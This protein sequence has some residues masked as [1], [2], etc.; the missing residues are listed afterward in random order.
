VHDRQVATWPQFLLAMEERLR[1]FDASKGEG[2]FVL[3]GTVSSPTLQAQLED[4]RTRYPRMQWHQY[5]P[6]HRDNE[7]RGSE[8]AFGRILD[9]RYRLDRARVLLTL[10]ADVICGGPHSTR[11]ARDL[12]ALRDPE[13]GP[14]SRI[15][16]L[17]SFPGLIGA[18]ADHRV[19]LRPA[20]IADLALRF[21]RSIL[22]GAALPGDAESLRLERPLLRDLMAA[23]REALVIPGSS[24]PAEVHAAAHALNHRFGGLG[25][26]FEHTLPVAFEPVAHIESIRQ[27]SAAMTEGRVK[28]LLIVGGNPVYDAPADLDFAAQL[29][30]VPE[31]IH[32][33]GY[34]D[35]TSLQCRW[36]VPLAHELEQ[37]SDV[38]AFDGTASIVQPTIA[39][40]YGGR[41]AH[42]ILNVLLR[43]GGTAYDAVRA[44]WRARFGSAADDERWRTSLRDGLV[45]GSQ[46]PAVSISPRPFDS[47]PT[48]PIPAALTVGFVPDQSARDGEFANNAWLQEL[49]RSMSKIVWDN[50]AYLSPR[51]AARLQLSTGDEIELRRA[52]RRVHAGV[53][54]LPAHADD[55]VTLPLG[56]GRTHAGDVGNGVGFDA[57]QLRTM[58][59]PWDGPVQIARTG[60]HRV[61]VSTQHHSRMEGRD[62]I[63]TA[64]ASEFART[65]AFATSHAQERVPQTTLYPDFPYE[66]YKW[67]MV[68]DLN[69]CIG[70]N[71]C[72]IACQAEN[73]IPVVGKE[74]VMRGREM[75]WLRI[76]RYERD[77]GSGVDFQPVACMH[78]ERAPCEEVCPVGATLHDSEGLNV[79]VYNRC[80]GTRF[81]SNNCPYKVR[82]FNFLQYSNQ[83]VEPLKALQNPEVTVRER[84]VMEKCSYCIQRITRGHIAAEKLGRRIQDG[85]VVTAC[86]AACPT[87]A[88]SFGDLN[89]PSSQVG[90]L[91][92]SPRNYSLL[93]QLN[94][95]PRTT[96]LAQVVNPDADSNES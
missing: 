68:I 85:E 52:G 83:S 9:T 47:L 49:P 42:E 76:D 10:D 54:I 44:Y 69:A 30:R 41:S 27:L 46:A 84:G 50:A 19:A 92:A 45:A 48:P 77:D 73:N 88:I 86:Q 36:H 70:C 6:L 89:D 24:M 26:T 60:R 79:Q 53:W 62:L 25:H 96:Y 82:R 63:R 12:A 20:A 37:W 17:E 67:G 22:Q 29:R 64:T 51:T 39:P 32:L 87:Q 72:T 40:L 66:G 34:V 71:A 21:S 56:Y 18:R 38:R 11:Y 91:K 13:H 95:R 59:S 16:A 1:S 78:C 94:T 35:E 14:M 4:L 23:G 2:L 75:H 55:C 74:Q 57:Y 8:L 90:K 93:A 7:L 31:S 28:L 58:D 65:P 33:A 43:H 80:V 81:C 15:Y 61:L 3:T 5:D